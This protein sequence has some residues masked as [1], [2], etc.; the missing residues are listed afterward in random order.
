MR[1]ARIWL[2]GAS[3]AACSAHTGERSP[4]SSAP[5]AASVEPGSSSSGLQTGE[6]EL[7]VS[8]SCR[9][10]VR[11]LRGKLSLDRIDP[12]APPRPSSD[13]DNAQL[14]WGRT[15]L[16]VAELRRCVD[17]RQPALEEPIHPNLLVQVLR[18]EGEEHRDV[19]LVTS[20]SGGG[21][22]SRSGGIA[23]WIERASGGE[24]EGMWSRWERAE[25]DEGRWRATLVRASHEAAR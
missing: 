13:P 12:A 22:S 24:L 15:D 23:L 20:E 18:W 10:E 11:E 7:A 21:T 25:R 4:A 1:L 17:V 3:I 16:D 19:L 9:S 14:L 6:Y 5:R 2:L 8:V